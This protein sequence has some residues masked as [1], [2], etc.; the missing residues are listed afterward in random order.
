MKF[1]GSMLGCQPVIIWGNATTYAVAMDN[2]VDWYV[3]TI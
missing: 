2:R 3:S 1:S